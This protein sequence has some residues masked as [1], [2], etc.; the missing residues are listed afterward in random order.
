MVT[1]NRIK[2]QFSVDPGWYDQVL[3]VNYVKIEYWR[4]SNK[5]DFKLNWSKSSVLS[6]LR[7]C[8]HA[9]LIL[10]TIIITVPVIFVIIIIFL[11]EKHR[12]RRHHKW[13]NIGRFTQKSRT[14]W[15]LI[16]EGFL[17]QIKE[18][19]DPPFLPLMNTYFSVFF[20]ISSNCFWFFSLWNLGLL[21]FSIRESRATH[22]HSLHCISWRCQSKLSSLHRVHQ[23]LS[24]LTTTYFHMNLANRAISYMFCKVRSLFSVQHFSTLHPFLLK[25]TLT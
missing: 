23:Y 9:K 24:T 13:Q 22:L 6:T 17:R 7:S 14:A 12:W 4:Q 21:C 2:D 15:C 10:I 16:R 20:H 11:E 8:P 19:G 3:Y 1:K 18:N 25:E 5:W